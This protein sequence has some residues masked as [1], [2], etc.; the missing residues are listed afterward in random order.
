MWLLIN[1]T[2]KLLDHMGWEGEITEVKCSSTFMKGMDLSSPTHA[3]RS[4]KEDC[5]PGK[6]QE[7]VVT[8]SCTTYL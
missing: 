3:L 8:T 2:E 6:H 5:T 4:L 1:H 7:I